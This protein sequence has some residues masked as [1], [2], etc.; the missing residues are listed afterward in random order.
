MTLGLCN[1]QSNIYELPNLVNLTTSCSSCQTFYSYTYIP[2]VQLYFSHNVIH[3]YI[4]KLN[5]IHILPYIVMHTNKFTLGY[6]HS[7]PHILRIWV[8]P[9]WPPT[10]TKE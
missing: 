2:F 1:H 9:S 6:T 10:A 3:A 7:T 4:F 5:K 8:F